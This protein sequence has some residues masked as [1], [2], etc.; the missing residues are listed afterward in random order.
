M[1]HCLYHFAP[2][3][4]QLGHLLEQ[5]QVALLSPLRERQRQLAHRLIFGNDIDRQQHA[6]IRLLLRVVEARGLCRS[7]QKLHHSH[8]GRRMYDCQL[9][10]CRR[11]G[12]GQ[13]SIVQHSIDIGAADGAGGMSGRDDHIA[14]RHKQIGSIPQHP[15][16]FGSHRRVGVGQQQ[17]RH[18]R[19][20]RLS[21]QAAAPLQRLQAARQGQ[22]DVGR[23]FARNSAQ[24]FV[25]VATLVCERLQR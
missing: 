25:R 10:E 24:R 5:L 2:F 14:I 22:A 8:D 17:V 20:Q 16:R 4:R 12:D 13:R 15:Q 6:N 1:L 9:S 23:N 21:R 18:E 7:N 11:S 19:T 3:G